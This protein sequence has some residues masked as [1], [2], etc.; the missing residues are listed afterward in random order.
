MMGYQ[1]NDTNGVAGAS[2]DM[3]QLNYLKFYQF[4]AD[5]VAGKIDHYE[6]LMDEIRFFRKEIVDIRHDADE[7]RLTS[8]DRATMHHYQDT[9]EKDL[10]IIARLPDIATLHDRLDFLND[11]IEY[12]ADLWGID[13]W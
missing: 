7:N 9:I 12:H 5:A 3:F 10:S 2:G 6:D 4:K 1:M 11:K 13:S 8:D